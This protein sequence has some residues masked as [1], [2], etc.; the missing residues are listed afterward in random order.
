MLNV[1]TRTA[2]QEAAD[3]FKATLGASPPYKTGVGPFPATWDG[4]K[5][6]Y[7]VGACAGLKSCSNA[8]LCAMAR[9]ARPAWQ[10]LERVHAHQSTRPSWPTRCAQ[11]CCLAVAPRMRFKLPHAAPP[12]AVCVEQ[13][14]WRP[15]PPAGCSH[16]P[17]EE[18]W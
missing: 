6:Y 13:P 16:Q 9:A 1:F 11:A 17:A 18:Q 8:C 12:A 10:W 4:W 3:A 14:C 7:E 15:V 2:L 5:A